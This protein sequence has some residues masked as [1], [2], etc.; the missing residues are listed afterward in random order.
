MVFRHASLCFFLTALVCSTASAVDPE[1]S[2]ERIQTLR[3]R[4]KDKNLNAALD[5]ALFMLDVSKRI[6]RGYPAQAAQWRARFERYLKDIETGQNP[7]DKEGGNIAMRGYHSHASTIG[8]GYSVYLPPGYDPKKKYPLMIT[9]HGGSS[10]GNLFLGVV[11]G[12]NMNWKKYPQ[13]LWD[14]FKPRYSPDW[15]VVAPD[16]YGQVLWRWMGEQDVLDVLDDVQSNYSVDPQRIVLA[17]LSNGGV[18]AYSIGMRHAWRFSAVVC[19]AGAPTW[20]QYTGG[21]A[22]SDELAAMR[23]ISSKALAENF[24]NTKALLFHGRTDTGPMKPGFVFDFENYLKEQK[25]PHQMTWF[26]AGHDILYMAMKHG[27]IF[28]QLESIHRNPKPHDVHVVTSDLRA[29]RQHWL[30]ITRFL[31]W[32]AIAK[33]H[34]TTKD[35]SININTEKVAAFI[36]HMIDVPIAQHAKLTITIDKAKVF[37]GAPKDL[38]E[39]PEFYNDGERWMLKRSGSSPQKSEKRIG[40][41]GPITDAYREAML[42]VYGTLDAKNTAALKAAAQKGAKGWPLW[43]WNYQQRVIADTELTAELAKS[44]HLVLYG[45]PHSNSVLE[46]IQNKL[47]IRFDN[48]TLM[49]GTKRYNTPTVGARFIYPNPEAPGRYVIAQLGLTHQ[50]VDAGHR[51]PDFVPDYVIYDA[52]SLR[53]RPRLILGTKPLDSGYFNDQWQLTSRRIAVEQVPNNTDDTSF[54]PIDRITNNQ[55]HLDVRDEALVIARIVANRVKGFRKYREEIPH[56]IWREAPET[57]W[58]VRPSS[59]CMTQLEALNIDSDAPQEQLATPVP[60]PRI[61]KK[62]VSG[63]RYVS[64]HSDREVMLACEMLVRLEVL[65]R[66]LRKYGITQVGVLSSYRDKPFTSFHT[67]G[68]GLDLA[69]FKTKTDKL[70]VKEDFIVSPDKATCPAPTY[71]SE[72][73]NTLAQ[74]ACDLFESRAFSSVLTPNYNEGHRDHF[75]LDARPND[76]RLYVR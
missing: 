66:V 49:A 4:T 20:E 31:D 47:P 75:H 71:A 12:N 58:Q 26:D 2:T 14:E 25:I 37:D 55:P 46:R 19:M 11:L 17:G 18:G 51:L 54:A 16:G 53:A 57:K 28:N 3:A 13:Y 40:L 10:N 62:V 21:K 9:L 73:A 70:I 61:V 29:A 32:P 30:S 41:S 33:I 7:Y 56:S 39:N 34:A 44:H 48:Q 38:G 72:K 27:K 5:G 52:G 8:Q 69:Y 45:T 35:T 42:H 15:I 6:E 60:T 59:E 67:F 36:M 65:A 64:L 23:A 1:T 43:L 50:A 74:L 68:L 76:A 22:N 24:Y 63:I